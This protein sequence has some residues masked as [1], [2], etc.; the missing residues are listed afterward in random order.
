[1]LGFFDDFDTPEVLLYIMP[2]KR[3]MI[4]GNKHHPGALPA[5]AQYFLYDVIMRLRPEPLAFE[6]PAIDNVTDQ[7]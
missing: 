4:A 1:M 3:V 5:F 6:L 2:G 7:I